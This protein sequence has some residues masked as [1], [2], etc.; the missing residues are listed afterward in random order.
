MAVAHRDQG[1]DIA[2][3]GKGWHWAVATAVT[4]ALLVAVAPLFLVAA[5]IDRAFWR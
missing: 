5:V 1:L 4:V 3:D 2:T